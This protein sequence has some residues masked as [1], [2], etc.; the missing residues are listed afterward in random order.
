MRGGGLYS[1]LFDS[2]RVGVTGSGGDVVMVHLG[3]AGGGTGGVY[4]DCVGKDTIGLKSAYLTDCKG[5]NRCRGRCR[6]LRSERDEFLYVFVLLLVVLSVDGEFFVPVYDLDGLFETFERL[7]CLPSFIMQIPLKY[8]YGKKK[9]ERE[10]LY[11][12]FHVVNK[13]SGNDVV[14]DQIEESDH[15][16]QDEGA[17]IVRIKDEVPSTIAERAK[18]SQK[19]RKAAEG[20]S[21][22]SPPPKKLRANH[23]TSGDGASTGG[24]SVAALQGLL[25]RS[26]L[27]I[28]V[29]V[30]MVATLLFITSYV[31]LKLERGGCRYSVIGLSLR[32]HHPAKRFVVLSD[33]HC[34]SSSNATDAKVSS[35]VMSLVPE[36]PIMTAAVATTV[37][38]DT[39][40]VLVPRI[41]HEPVHQTIFMDSASMCEASPDVAGPSYPAGT[42]L[43]AD[44]FY[45]SQDVD[46]ETLHQIY[47]PKWNV[48]NDSALDDPD[49]CH[50]VIDHLALLVLFPQLRSI[51][52]D[53][54][55]VEF[56]VRVARQTCLSSEVRLQLEHELRGEKKFEG[57]CVMQADLLKEKDAKIVSL[58]AQLSLKEAEA[59]EILALEEEKSVLESKVVALESANAT[60]VVE[61]LSV[62]ASS[63][64][65]KRD[66]LISQDEQVKVL[67]VKVAGLDAELMGMAL[68]L[69]EEF[70]PCFLTT[71]AGRSILL[72]LGGAIDRAIDKGIQDGL[73]ACINHGKTGRGL[74]DVA[75]YNPSAKANYVFAINALCDMDFPLL[76]QL[77]SQ[78]DASITDIMGLLHLEGPAVEFIPVLKGFEEMPRVPAVVSVATALSTTF[79]E[80]NSVPPIPSYNYEVVDTKAQAETS[81]SHKIIF[82]EETLETSSENPAT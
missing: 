30:T 66:R 73:A 75:T 34:H 46:S 10:R 63:L 55:F 82:E 23:G 7:T 40:S 77:E 25:E 27:P 19:K 60:K 29:G 12:G 76:A 57:K 51:D 1:A 58:K 20:A 26:T 28:K 11:V 53:Q 14:A 49:V 62:K 64:E 59:V 42:E 68:H 39:S 44:S 41:G 61:L 4:V 5:T 37:V 78:K 79:V 80:A 9:L 13:E 32:T 43:S 18:G 69:D 6:C 35:V 21:G 67:S 36:P 8:R 50:G 22:S 38:A 16:V 56:N 48:N 70:Y 33:S 81:S 72:L 54:L 52:Y 74:V 71:I 15:V 17:N 65:V 47:V 31:S 2:A 45:V 3:G 24:K